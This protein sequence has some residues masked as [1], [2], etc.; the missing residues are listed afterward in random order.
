M[1]LE[2]SIIMTLASIVFQQ[3]IHFDSTKWHWYKIKLHFS[4]KNASQ[5]K[6]CTQHIHP[7]WLEHPQFSAQAIIVLEAVSK[8]KNHDTRSSEP[9][10]AVVGVRRLAQ[11]LCAVDLSWWASSVGDERP[12]KKPVT[13]HCKVLY[14]DT[15]SI[16]A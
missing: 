8:R 5:D 3:C 14:V 6:N 16:F 2:K 13:R 11:I 12:R 9:K 7:H 4:P 1:V 10:W 15:T